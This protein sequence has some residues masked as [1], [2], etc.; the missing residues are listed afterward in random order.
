MLLFRTRLR[1][2][3]L[4]AA[5]AGM[6]A[7]A[8]RPPI[9]IAAESPAAPAAAPVLRPPGIVAASAYLI[10]LETGEPLFEKFPTTRRPMASTTKIMTGLLAAES[11]RLN[12]IATVSRA[13]AIIGETTM[14]LVEGERVPLRELLYGLMLPSG[15]DAAVVLAEHLSGSVP[16]FV[17]Q[18][19]VRALAMGLWDTQ[20]SNPHGLDHGRFS[21]PTHFSSARDLAL[22]GAA[23]VKVPVL[24]QVM[25]TTQRDIPA[26][27]TG[28]RHQLR[29][30]VS[31]LWW[32]PGASGVKTGWTE[33]AGQVRVTSATRGTT[34]LMAVVMDSPDHI[35]ET[36]ALF[37]YGFAIRGTTPT[38]ITPTSLEAFPLPETRLIQAWE[39]YK[40]LAVGQDGRVRAGPT[41][42]N[43]TSD[44]Q[45]ATL[46][47]AVW[48]RDRATFD[49]VWGW[50]RATLWRRTAP[51]R[52]ALFAG[53]WANGAVTDWNNAAGADQRIAAALLLASHLWREESYAREADPILDS[54]L[55]KSA[56]SWDGAGGVAAANAFL[57]TLEPVTTSATALTPAF[58]RMFAEHTDNSIWLWLLDGTYGTLQAAAGSGPLGASAT[59]LPA[60]YAVSRDDGQVS[61]PVDPAW[62]S[63]GFAEGSPALAYQLALEWRWNGEP[64]AQT[65]LT[66]TGRTL[67]RDLLARQRLA[68]TY[69]RAGVPGAIET[70]RYGALASLAFPEVEPRA[71]AMLLPKLEQALQSRDGPTILDGIDGLWL[72]AGGPPNFWRLWWPPDDLPT[73]R[74]DNVT[75]PE[76]A[77]ARWRYF[78]ET[79]HV[80]QGNFLDYFMASGGVTIF[81]FPRT[82][83]MIENERL[84]QHFQ[85]ARLEVLPSGEVMAMPL[86][87][88]AA[89]SRG[90]MARP[91]A[92]PIVPFES[93]SARLFVPATGHSIGSG[94]RIFLERAGGWGILGLPLTEEFIDDGFTVQYFERGVLEYLPGRPIQVELLGDATLRERGWLK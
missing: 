6:L 10:D 27:E 14:G 24:A 49:T 74:V 17:D 35:S 41:G 13:A 33:K 56:I 32:Y 73:T 79:G 75:P 88:L 34:R 55:R 12:E 36:R 48:F 51:E 16:A 1:P 93:D 9:Q 84:V 71:A 86:G 77:S 82:E 39:R 91:E 28:P 4:A 42:N 90:V 54:V 81:G 26:S 53:Q 80:V 23:A 89:Y 87:L 37:D 7:V 94:F 92:R 61:E 29:S 20:F 62:M 2:L 40:Q 45:A 19:N 31:A 8:G 68:R 65:L 76:D 25:G 52:D 47:H 22:L 66:T 64:R 85:R 15:N 59:V 3:I 30:T 67:A 46:L 57:N 69:T 78:P 44:G 11:G 50:T 70:D 60:W 18:M 21:S 38:A 43:T 63:T 58:Y 72:L 5:I 83:A